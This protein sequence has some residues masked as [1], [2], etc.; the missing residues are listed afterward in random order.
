MR[1]LTTRRKGF[2]GR[3]GSDQCASVM[4]VYGSRTSIAIGLR[5]N[6]EEKR[7]RGSQLIALE[8]TLTSI[9][10]VVT[11]KRLTIVDGKNVFAPGNLRASQERSVSLMLKW[12]QFCC[13]GYI[14]VRNLLLFSGFCKL[15]RQNFCLY[16]FEIPFPLNLSRGKRVVNLVGKVWVLLVMDRARSL[17]TSIYYVGVCHVNRLLAGEQ[18]H[19]A[20]HRGDSPRRLPRS[21]HRVWSIL[22]P[23]VDHT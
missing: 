2:I 14:Q 5:L 21:H 9:G 20:V 15:W 16:P 22:Q 10:W 4:A 3:K 1:P 13:K 7:S 17:N 11:R 6:D 12:T 8:V 18:V 23:I 19:P